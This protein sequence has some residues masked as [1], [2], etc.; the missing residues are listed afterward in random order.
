M[1][2]SIMWKMRCLR[3]KF[4]IWLK[5]EILHLVEKDMGELPCVED[6]VVCHYIPSFI[7]HSYCFWFHCILED[8]CCCSFV[9]VGKTVCTQPRSFNL[10]STLLEKP[11]IL[12]SEDKLIPLLKTASVIIL[13]TCAKSIGAGEGCWRSLVGRLCTKSNR[14]CFGVGLRW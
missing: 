14:A 2:Q 1:F 8:Y 4:Y 3:W 9:F 5:M 6:Q 13:L 10:S 12:D 7:L 11:D